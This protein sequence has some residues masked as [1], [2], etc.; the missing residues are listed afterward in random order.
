M[1]VGT[2]GRFITVEGIEGV[3]KS[4][5]M[6]F[7]AEWLQG[8][9]VKLVRTREPGGTPMAEEIRGLLLQHREE[10][11]AET[12]ELLLMFA[13]RAQHLQQLV[14]PALEQG[15]WVLS[16]R[17]TDATFAY[18][19]GGRGL[20]DAKIAELEQFVQGDFRPDLTLVLDAPPEIGM[21]RVARRGGEDRFE[22]ER[23]EFFA[24]VRAVYL[25]R[26]KRWP[27]RY[28]IIDAT[29]P[30]A[31]VQAAVAAVLNER[32]DALTA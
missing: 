28:A 15:T 8:R 24:R 31:L 21:A 29:Q 5:N 25:E 18:Q 10:A 1:S 26:A 2:R 12:T 20:A 19:G 11:V 4:T 32:F 13:A 30:L 9:G 7:V 17:F 27:D 22:L 23:H 3:G 6:A 14:W 16:D